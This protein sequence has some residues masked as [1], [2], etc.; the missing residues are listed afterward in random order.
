MIQNRIILNKLV[1]LD[2]EYRSFIKF[3]DF[4]FEI[5]KDFFK[6]EEICKSS[7]KTLFKYLLDFENQVGNK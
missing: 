6:L 7:I 3:E 4:Y 2:S 5:K 1:V